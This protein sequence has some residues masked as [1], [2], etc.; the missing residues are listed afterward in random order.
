M[1]TGCIGGFYFTKKDHGTCLSNAVYKR[2]PSRHF[3]P[4]GQVIRQLT[5][6]GLVYI[7]R[8]NGLRLA[9]YLDT[10]KYLEQPEDTIEHDITRSEPCVCDFDPRFPHS[11][12]ATCTFYRGLVTVWEIG[13]LG[14]ASIC[15]AEF[16]RVLNMI[17]YAPSGEFIA[18][19]GTEGVVTCINPED[20]SMLFEL[21]TSNQSPQSRSTAGVYQL[22][23]SRCQ[24][25]LAASY[26]DGFIRIWQLPL[27]VNL[28]DLCRLA[29]NEAVPAKDIHKLPVPP[30][31][32][33]Y[34]LYKTY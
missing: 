12:I 32:K 7:L 24:G 6:D 33:S 23:F 18:V 21:N 19:A 29:I 15:K 11:V 34:L 5:G 1:G 25:K 17:K 9:H 20:A 22:A 26:S 16:G 30:R 13:K 31:I 28:Q 8:T 14:R 27:D 4:K 10:A 2:F 3:A